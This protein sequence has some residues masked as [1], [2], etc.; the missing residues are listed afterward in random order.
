MTFK[1]FRLIQNWFFF[2]PQRNGNTKKSVLMKFSRV[3]CYSWRLQCLNLRHKSMELWS[4]SIW[5]VYRFNK[6][7]SLRHRSQRELLTGCKTRCR[8]ES[9]PFTLWTNRKS[10][11][12]SLL[13]SSR[14]F[15]RNCAIESSSM[16]LIVN[17]FT[18]I[19]RQSVCRNATMEPSTF[20]ELMALNGSSCCSNVIRSTTLWIVTDISKKE[21]QRRRKNATRVRFNHAFTEKHLQSCAYKLGQG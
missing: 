12:W 11:T 15:A 6:H 14:S 3:V 20:L 10:L 21:T 7:G 4:Y 17:H 1:R 5:T 16:E 19:L 8:W 18:S 13:Y 2:C 9:K